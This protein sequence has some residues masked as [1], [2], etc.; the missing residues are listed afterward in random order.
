MHRLSDSFLT[1]RTRTNTRTRTTT[2]SAR[3][4]PR[5]THAPPAPPV[6]TNAYCSP[7]QSMV[8]QD[9]DPS[10]LVG[11][12]SCWCRT[13]SSHIERVGLC[14]AH[15]QTPAKKEKEKLISGRWA[16]FSPSSP[17]PLPL[18]PLSTSAS[19]SLLS[20]SASAFASLSPPSHTLSSSNYHNALSA[21]VSVS[22]VHNWVARKRVPASTTALLNNQN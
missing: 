13:G 19:S 2:W 21:A 22:K 7:E 20:L 17:P 11:M 1:R 3:H 18:H 9:I 14:F 4:A 12:S 10:S 5:T 16:R 6:H 15:R 8:R